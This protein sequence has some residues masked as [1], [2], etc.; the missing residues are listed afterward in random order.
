MT[1]SEIKTCRHC[2]D[3]PS[4]PQRSV[5]WGCLEDLDPVEYKRLVEI[6]HRTG[7]FWA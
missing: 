7:G 5:C 6:D 2:C 4:I 3:L 1:E